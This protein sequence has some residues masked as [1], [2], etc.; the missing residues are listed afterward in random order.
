MRQRIAGGVRRKWLVGAAL[1]AAAALPVGAQGTGNGY[2]F[3]A[4][5]GGL[6]IRAGWF[7]ASANS[8]FFDEARQNFTLDK[9]DFGGPNIGAD[10]A[11]RL[12]PQLDLTFDGA[13]IGSSHKSHY[14]RLVDA[15]NKE[16]EQTTTLRR[17]PLT[18]NIK[19]Y[20]VPRGRSVG[21]LAY[22]P[23]KVVPWIGVGGGLTWY[24]LEQSGDFVVNPADCL[25][26]GNSTS[27]SVFN[28]RL[29][30]SAWGPAVQGM[31]GVDV[32]LTPRI[33]LTGDARYLWSRASME[34]SFDGFE[35]ID[36]SGVSIALGVTFRL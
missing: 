3:G 9:G 17:V 35:K 8:D 32:T 10:V 7:I 27:C 29:E 12:T 33:A 18:A 19:A 1:V 24:K 15:D 25:A 6:T 28:D 26:T 14:R 23:A 21:S 4:P 5:T 30:S 2:L 20:L 16:I 22:I 11:I 36:L 13:W 34:D 31:G